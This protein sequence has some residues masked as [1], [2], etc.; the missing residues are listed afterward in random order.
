MLGFALTPVAC[1]YVLA[2][3]NKRGTM[4][5]PENTK[6][7][8]QG[9]MPKMNDGE[10]VGASNQMRVKV[11]PRVADA[12]EQE[13][14]LM[15][16]NAELEAERR[17]TMQKLSADSGEQSAAALPPAAASASAGGS[18]SYYSQYFGRLWPFSA[19]R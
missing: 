18:F 6:K 2:Q 14:A 1:V 10:N 12:L 17:A 8:L 11:L 15:D 4:V 3:E 5:K 7:W 9:S 13:V 19:K 16:L